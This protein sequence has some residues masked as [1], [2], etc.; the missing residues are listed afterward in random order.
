[1]LEMAGQGGRHLFPFP[2]L[3]SVWFSLR[4]RA[5][6]LIVSGRR[7]WAAEGGRPSQVRAPIKGVGLITSMLSFCTLAPSKLA[8]M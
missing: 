8:H 4:K 3:M 6:R 7:R 2:C 5:R 1:M